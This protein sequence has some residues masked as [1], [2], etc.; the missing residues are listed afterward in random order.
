MEPDG[1]R[2]KEDKTGG[3]VGPLTSGFLLCPV[4]WASLP[5]PEGFPFLPRMGWMGW[6]GWRGGQVY[7]S[8]MWLGTWWVRR[9]VGPQEAPCPEYSPLFKISV[10]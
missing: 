3:K 2:K 7:R 4:L 5:S 9:R 10:K 6:M 1:D 8:G